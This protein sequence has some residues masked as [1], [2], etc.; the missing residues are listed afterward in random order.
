MKN[1]TSVSWGL[2]AILVLFGVPAAFGQDMTD[3]QKAALESVGA[4]VYPGATF[5]TADEN[6]HV[7]LWFAS[8]ESPDA[9]M[10]WYEENLSDWSAATIS[11]TRLV[12]KGPAG[13]GK[14]EMMALPYIFVTSA[15][16]LGNDPADDN[17][18]TIRIP[19][20]P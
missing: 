18:I 20:P 19:D 5:L 15:E 11:S 8:P 4:P 13:I 12:Y 9:I 16:K 1:K 3:S 7:V 6:G 2:I 10:D 17:E 14:E